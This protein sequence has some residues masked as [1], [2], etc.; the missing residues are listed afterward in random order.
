MGMLS[1]GS[2]MMKGSNPRGGYSFVFVGFT[3]RDMATEML[4]SDPID[5][6]VTYTSPFCDA[7]YAAT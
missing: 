1:F 2:K 7:Y 3:G 5:L 6:T 4:R